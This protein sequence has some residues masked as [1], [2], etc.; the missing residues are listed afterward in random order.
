[1]VASQRPAPVA[2]YRV[3][4]WYRTGNKELLM[5]AP[6]PR[7]RYRA[8]PVRMF[9]FVC[10]L[11]RARARSLSSLVFLKLIVAHVPTT[12]DQ[13]AKQFERALTVAL[14]S[15][16]NG[17]EVN[18]LKE[19]DSVDD[20]YIKPLFEALSANS[21]ETVIGDPRLA[22]HL[23]KALRHLHSAENLRFW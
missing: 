7:G 13:S 16:W 10:V 21:V 11:F 14:D 20:S 6:A 5:R 2:D 15:L 23:D 8:P 1:M 22:Q 12:C 4:V 18:E 19:L 3:L 17:R 9:S